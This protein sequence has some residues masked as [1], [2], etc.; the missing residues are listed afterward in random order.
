MLM[1]AHYLHK[2]DL[3]KQAKFVKVCMWIKQFSSHAT[4]NCSFD[5]LFF[6]TYFFCHN[7]QTHFNLL[8]VKITIFH[9]RAKKE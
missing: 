6:F 9:G 3:A 7:N 5:I 1:D 2:K 4:K 8:I